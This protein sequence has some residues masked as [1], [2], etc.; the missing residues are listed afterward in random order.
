MNTNL[1]SLYMTV[2]PTHLRLIQKTPLFKSTDKNT[3]QNSEQSTNRPQG[4]IAYTAGVAVGGTLAGM[5][6]GVLIGAAVPGFKTLT[7]TV[8]GAI[9][10][11]ALSRF[12]E[13]RKKGPN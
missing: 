12:P 6:V 8:L 1:G 10:G 11:F 4:T 2:K 5:V 9:W 13:A 3:S 7:W